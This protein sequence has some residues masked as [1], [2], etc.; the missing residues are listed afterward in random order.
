[1]SRDRI[2]IAVACVFVL[3]GLIAG[4]VAIGPPG[5]ARLLQMDQRRVEDLRQI[6]MALHESYKRDRPLPKTLPQDL[7]LYARGD[8]THDPQTHQPYVYERIDAKKYRLCAVYALPSEDE[9]GVGKPAGGYWSH[10]AGRKC[11]T[12][13]ASYDFLYQ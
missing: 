12:L 9:P 6:S 3:A 13:D 4:F 10:G 2:Y 5:H 11:Y 1:M 7:T 8:F